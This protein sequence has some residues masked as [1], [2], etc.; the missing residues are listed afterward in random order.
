MYKWL[1][2]FL[3]NRTARV[4]VDGTISRQVKLREGVPQGGV[5]SPALFLVY[6]NDI[7]TTVPR[8]VSNTLH[9]DDFAVWCAEEHTTTAVHRIQNTINEVCSWTESWALQLNTTKTVSTLFTLSTAKEKVSLRLNKQPVPQVETPT[10]LGVPLDTRLTWKPHLEAVEA[11]A[12]R[13][14]AIMKKLTE[15]TWGANSDILKQVYT[16]AVRP[17]VEYASTIWDTASKT[18]KSKL[19]RVQN[20]GLRIILGAT[21]ST[22]MQK[23]EKTTNFQPLE[24]R[25]E[26]KARGKSWRDWPVI[27]STR[28]FSMEPKTAWKERASSTS[29][30]TYK[31]K[32][33]IFWRQI[34]ENV[35][36]S[37]WVSGHH[38]RAFQKSELKFQ[39]LQQREHRL[40]NC[41]KHSHWRWYRVAVL[42]APGPTSSQ[43]ALQRTLLG[44]E[45]V[46]LT[47][48]AQMEPPPPSPSQLVTWATTTEQ[49][50]TP[51]K[52]P[53]NSWLRKTATSR[54]L[55]CCLTPCLL[56]SLWQMVPPTFAPSN[57][58]AACVLYQTT[59]E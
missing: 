40:Q 46:V 5:V 58:T 1:S 31:K 7:T 47:S 59:T 21:R 17:V 12:T 27:H 11:K 37:Q 57:Y 25:C 13:K 36:N 49:K 28:N 51:G 10:F 56:F 29:W 20:M 24:G 39:A 38:G 18:N 53:Q 26:Y 50:Y 34:Q 19:D 44:L 9:A 6:I 14:L 2:D 4:K 33:L 35:R 42:R 55:S 54:I 43:M 3:F 52:L 15:T 41:R 30:R 23:M 32:M 45:A 8:R 16:G 48:V 22:P